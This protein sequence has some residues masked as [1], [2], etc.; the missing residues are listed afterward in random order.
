M[1]LIGMSDQWS[2]LNFEHKL[3][4]LKTRLLILLFSLPGAPIYYGHLTTPV[5]G[6]RKIYKSKSALTGVG[7][8]WDPSMLKLVD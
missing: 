2:Y 3:L 5:N 7:S 4:P 8:D 1:S 6:C